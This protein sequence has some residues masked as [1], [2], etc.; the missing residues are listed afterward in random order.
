MNA[1]ADPVTL[2]TLED[3]A[4]WRVGLATPKANIL[5]MEKIERLSSI[6]A[7]AAEQTG[8]KAILIEGQGAHFSF[9]ASVEE[10]MPGLFEAMIRRRWAAHGH[11]VGMGG[12]PC[13]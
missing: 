1:T 10:H 11:Q 5:D 7:R 9:G 3:G 12:A 4:V 8:L 2:E 13:S 6:F